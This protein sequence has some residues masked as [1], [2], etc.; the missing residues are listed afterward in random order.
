MLFDQLIH[1]LP[2][3]AG[4]LFFGEVSEKNILFFALMTPVGISPNK[5]DDGVNKN[6][7]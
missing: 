7:V 2:V 3:L 6:Q 1:D 5:V 4:K